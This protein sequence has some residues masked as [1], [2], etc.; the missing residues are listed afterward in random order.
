MQIA[1]TFI[2]TS[3]ESIRAAVDHIVATNEEIVDR[4]RLAEQ[5]S[6]GLAL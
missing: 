4:R 6:T 3:F 2:W 1:E 5:G